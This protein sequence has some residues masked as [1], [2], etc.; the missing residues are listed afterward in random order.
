MF[1]AQISSRYTIADFS[2]LLGYTKHPKKKWH[3]LYALKDL[4]RD[5]KGVIIT[6]R[7]LGSPEEA[8]VFFP[9]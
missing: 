2:T 4:P 9:V 1:V 3:V 7:P 6:L 5:Q 8:V